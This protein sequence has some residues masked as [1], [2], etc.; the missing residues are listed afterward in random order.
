MQ[1][2]D[3]QGIWWLPENPSNKIAGT[4][5]F[6]DEKGVELSLAGTFGEPLTT[7]EK[8]NI[9]ILLGQV[10]DCA[11]GEIVT[12]KACQLQAS[13][14]SS[15]VIAREEY[16]AERLFIGSHLEKEEDFL[17]SK[18]SI[19]LSGLPSWANSLRG[20]SHSRIPA[21]EVHRSGFEIRWLPPKPVAGRIPGGD[22][23]LRVGAKMSTDRRQ[24]SIKEEV[25]FLISCERP[26][27]DRDLN[28]DFV[29]PLQNFMT[30][31]TDTPNALV[32]FTV[33]RAG[34]PDNVHV[35]GARVFHDDE[36][37]TALFPHDMLFSLS[38]VEDRAVDLI[39]KWI[40]ISERLNEVCNLYFR[41]QYQADSFVETR[42]LLVCQSLEVYQRKR[43]P[44][45][46]GD[47]GFS[48]LVFRGQLAKLL[49]EHRTTVAPLFSNEIGQAIS[50]LTKYRSYV[51][52]HDFQ[53]GTDAD[54]GA[55]MFWLTQK[56]MFLMKAC[57]LTELGIPGED[58][59]KFFQRNRMY[60]H[61]LG[62]VGD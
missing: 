1:T 40:E 14:I 3:C 34:S 16:F 28:A 50:E 18:M 38:D 32:D 4:L 52:C 39:S 61:L 59:L 47:R 9:P 10:W 23:T 6:S 29:Y 56:L 55:K 11:L 8:R 27:S 21:D 7:L 45:S 60:V 46:E 51:V 31:A 33:S 25:G 42:F 26:A 54:Y 53:A 62:L 24:Y 5:R 30:L 22:L 17:F 19:Q 12:L 35:L 58:Q 13:H 2:F 44:A 57:L 49:E 48:E 43:Q 36:A 20:L 41:L 15:R 37:A